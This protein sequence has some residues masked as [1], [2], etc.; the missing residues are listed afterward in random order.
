MR[1]TWPGSFRDLLNRITMRRRFA[2]HHDLGLQLL[3]LYLL[4]IIPFLLTLWI[5]D[6]WIGVRIREDVRSSDLSL[7]ESISQEVELGISNALSTVEG[8]SAYPSVIHA[9]R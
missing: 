7:A 3:A 6:G 2:F 5:F 9:E 1:S 8:L 4:L